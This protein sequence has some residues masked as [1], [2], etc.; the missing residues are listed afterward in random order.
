MLDHLL[1]QFSFQS[2]CDLELTAQSLDAIQHH[3]VED[4]ALVLGSAV[5]QALGDRRGIVRFG[6]ATIPMDDALARA[7]VDLGGRAFARTA[8]LT[9]AQ[10]LEGLDTVMLPH[11]FRSLASTA[12]LTVHVDVL[13]GEDPHH[14]IEAA[15]KAFARACRSAWS[16]SPISAGT[17]PSTKGVL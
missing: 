9:Q 3:L 11:F 16:V 10:F 17:I 12:Q 7:A 14:C 1:A 8:F 2:G 5:A 4:V 6:S 15:F 13:H